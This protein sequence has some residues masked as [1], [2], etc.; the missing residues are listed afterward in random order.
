MGFP[1]K[2]WQIFGWPIL[3]HLANL[4]NF[5]S[6]PTVF[7]E[8]EHNFCIFTKLGVRVTNLPYLVFN[9]VTHKKSS[10]PGLSAQDMVVFS[11]N[12]EAFL[13]KV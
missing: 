2:I 8:Q 7:G 4:P 6:P 13:K 10:E 5:R 1:A 11:E 9:E 12:F 3:E